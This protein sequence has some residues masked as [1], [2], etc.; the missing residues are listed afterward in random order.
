MVRTP[1]L[2]GV[3]VILFLGLVVQWAIWRGVRAEEA[4]LS[5]EEVNLTAQE[6]RRLIARIARTR[7][8]LEPLERATL[9]GQPHRL[10]PSLGKLST[11]LPV[12]LVGVEEFP[13]KRR[14]GYQSFP[15]RLTFSGDYEG[16]SGLIAVL[17]QIRPPIRTDSLRLYKRQQYP[18]TLWLSL[19]VAPMQQEGGD[20]TATTVKI[21]SLTDIEMR[22]NPFAFWTPGHPEPPPVAREQQKTT[23]LPK[24]TGILWNEQKPVA[25]FTDHRQQPLLAH[26]SEVVAGATVTEIQPQYVVLKRGEL[27]HKLS[28]LDE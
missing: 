25:I 16:F 17:E 14:S 4:S 27:S 7:K 11:Q 18:D 19:I 20:D 1:F 26:V 2:W 21:P 5:D 28:L 15:L 24:L 3:V 22:R 6:H 10:L 12:K 9:W 13:P 8:K 23:P